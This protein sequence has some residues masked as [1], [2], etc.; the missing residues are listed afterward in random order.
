MDVNKII[1][2]QKELEA[3]LNLEA[4]D[5]LLELEPWS[6]EGVKQRAKEEGIDLTEEHLEVICF[7]RDYYKENGRASSAGVLTR[8][9]DDKYGSRG[10][11]KYLYRLFP[12]GPITQACK[13][14]GVPL[15]PYT[16]DPSF[17]SAE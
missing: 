11:R 16:I 14:G 6:E 9:L 5:H 12:R 4:E 8:L 7:L 3:N 15:P 2:E 10:G 1:L 17:G 13:I